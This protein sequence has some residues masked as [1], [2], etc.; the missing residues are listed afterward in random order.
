[1]LD[2]HVVI[3]TDIGAFSRY[4]GYHTEAIPV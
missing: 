4:F 1:M 3:K 2:G